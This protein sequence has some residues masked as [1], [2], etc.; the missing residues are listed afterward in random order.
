[1]TETTAN[2]IYDVLVRE[3]GAPEGMRESFLAVMTRPGETSEYRFIGDLGFGG[4]F[5]NTNNRFYVDCYSEHVTEARTQ[6]IDA[7]N[8]KLAAIK[9]GHDNE[10]F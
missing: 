7:A 3:C 2:E 4:K 6:M 8:V 9:R 5:R 1:M 10:I